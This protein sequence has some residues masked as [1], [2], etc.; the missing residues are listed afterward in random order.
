MLTHYIAV[1]LLPN[2]IRTQGLDDIIWEDTILIA[3]LPS[4]PR[5]L[6]SKTVMLG[7]PLSYPLSF[8]FLIMYLKIFLSDKSYR[9]MHLTNTKVGFVLISIIYFFGFLRLQLLHARSL[10]FIVACGICSMQ[11]LVPWPGIKPVPSALGAHS[12]S[13]RTTRDVLVKLK[14]FG[15]N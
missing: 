10:V 2:N 3:S 5:H 4:L 6:W 9:P 15:L 13:H 8:L 14:Q 12:L 7:I 11:N 1:T